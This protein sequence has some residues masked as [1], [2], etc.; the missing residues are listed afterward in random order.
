MM[1][2]AM[3]MTPRW[4]TMPPLARPIRPRHHP[5]CRARVARTD[6]TRA[7]IAV[8]AA[9][10]PR[11]KPTRGA[12]PRNPKATQSTTVSTPAHAGTARRCQSTAALILRQLNAGATA[13]KKSNARP[14]GTATVSKKGAAT[15]TCCCVTAS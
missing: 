2:I 10:A 6:S 5:T 1:P 4:T 14:T 9:N 3:T 7:R 12:R 8:A 15:L 13:I 11:P